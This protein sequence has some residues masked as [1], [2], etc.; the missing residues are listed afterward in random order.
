MLNLSE[1]FEKVSP[2]YGAFDQIKNPPSM[3]PDLCAFI[4]LDKIVPGTG[5]MITASEHDEFFLCT[6]CEALAQIAT[7]QDILY[8]TR[9]GVIYSEEYDCLSMF[10]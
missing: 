3:R 6:D 4:L 9:C 10:S 7:A 8:L 5:D 1:E 2:A